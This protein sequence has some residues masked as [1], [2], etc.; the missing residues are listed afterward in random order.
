[1]KR[2]CIVVTAFFIC[3][4]SPFG[5]TSA[6]TQSPENF[7]NDN[8]RPLVDLLAKIS[9][10]F[11][12]N[13]SYGSVP[14]DYLIENGNFLIRP[15]SVEESLDNVLT[16]AGCTFRFDKINNR[17]VVKK[18]T[19]LYE[20]PVEEGMAMLE[21]LSTLYSDKSSWEARKDS[22][23]TALRHNMGLDKLPERFNGKVYLTKKRVYGDYYVQNFGI[24]ILPGLYTT[25][26]IYHP[27]KYKKGKCP[28][29]INP[30]GHYQTGRYT[31]LIQIRCAM[32]ARMGCVALV[33]DMFAW[34]EQPM[35]DKAYHQTSLAQ[36][37]QVLSALRLLDYAL[38][39]P[40]ADA[41]RVAVTGSSGGGSQTM[42]ACAIDDR[43]TLSMPVV[44][45][46]SFFHGGCKCESGTDIHLSGGG[47]NNVEIASLFAPKPMLIVSD[48]ADWT[49][50]TPK[51]EMPFVKRVYGFYGAENQVENAHFADEVHDYGP[52]KRQATYTFLEKHWE[53]DTRKLKDEN[54]LFDE[55]KCIV[56]DFDLL[57]PWGTNEEN[58]PEDA[59]SDP[60]KLAE[61]LQWSK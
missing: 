31:D 58:W 35:F 44:M 56:E 10:R 59:I 4:F 45:M 52:S 12:V 37:V 25:G 20:Y 47:T 43:I 11:D 36:T 13:I 9:R 50:Y 42:F 21:Y 8:K 30:H 2:T 18:Q 5:K 29:I 51:V 27:T 19:Q 53:L 22:L 7:L 54:G 61:L 14:K 48:G 24:E 26:S 34:G 57:K 3:M 46:S 55:S 16:P 41:S 49:R 28:I 15:W 6:Q 38:A 17:Y 32:Q 33:Y 1:M 60:A 40:E 39:L 23:R